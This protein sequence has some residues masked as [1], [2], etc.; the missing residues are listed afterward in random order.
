MPNITP[1]FRV[2]GL[3]CAIEAALPARAADFKIYYPDADK[4]D[5]ELESRMF[6][7]FDRNGDRRLAFDEYLALVSRVAADAPRAGQGKAP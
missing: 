1:L 2:L 4:G 3:L 7:T 6:D 5:L